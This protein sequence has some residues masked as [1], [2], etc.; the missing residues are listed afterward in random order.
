MILDAVSSSEPG[1]RATA[2]TTVMRST[3]ARHWTKASTPAGLK[4]Q[5]IAGGRIVGVDAAGV[6]QTSAD[7]GGSWNAT[8][9]A[10]QLPS[11]AP[12]ATVMAADAGPLG[13]A[14]LAVAD[15]DPMDQQPGHDYLLFSTDGTNWTTSDL[16]AIGEPKDGYATSV[17]VGADHIGVNYQGPA[18]T[19][20][21]LSKLTTLLATPQR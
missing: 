5:A 4:V 7:G 20:G 8:S 9:I 14:V 13:F 11:G 21:G 3:D 18:V 2:E 16:A 15:A 12:A 10:T 19:N 1:K 6:L 17:T